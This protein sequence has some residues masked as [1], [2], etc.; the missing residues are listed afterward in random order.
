MGA[1]DQALVELRA[2]RAQAS[3]EPLTALE[4][5]ISYVECQRAGMGNSEQWVAAGYPIGSGGGA[6]EVD[7]V[8]HWR[9]KQQGRR[10]KR[11]NAEAVVA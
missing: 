5:A 4:K 3:P 1:V 11:A 9:M 6:R 10:W 8:I 2:W 7:V